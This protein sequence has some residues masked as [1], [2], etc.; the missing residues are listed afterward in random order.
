MI[1][2]CKWQPL[3][4]RDYTWLPLIRQ[5]ECSCTTATKHGKLEVSDALFLSLSNTYTDATKIPYGSSL[6]NT[7]DY[8]LLLLLLL[9]NAVLYAFLTPVTIFCIHRKCVADLRFRART[10]TYIHMYTQSEKANAKWQR[11]LFSS[12][13][14]NNGIHRYNYC[15]TFTTLTMY[16]FCSQTPSNNNSGCLIQC[17]MCVWVYMYVCMRLCCIL[18]MALC[19]FFWLCMEKFAFLHTKNFP[20]TLKVDFSAFSSPSPHPFLPQLS[21]SFSFFFYF[22]ASLALFTI[23][24]THTHIQLMRRSTHS[25]THL[26]PYLVICYA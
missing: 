4:S 8:L 17:S 20:S 19:F 18:W 1:E 7:I 15:T 5:F 6:L 26:K 3:L 22:I 24:S 2:E 11:Q 16:R 25:V 12:L 9:L 14:H 21:F 23:I 13:R 10:Y